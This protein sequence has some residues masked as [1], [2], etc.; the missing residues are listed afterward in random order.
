ML[1]H[2]VLAVSAICSGLANLAL[3][4]TLLHPLGL[5]GV[6]LGTLIP[7]T[8]ECIGFVLPYATRAI[9][10]SFGEVR[11]Q[12]LLPTLIPALPMAILVYGLGDTMGPLSIASLLVVVGS[13][14]LIYLVGY[15]SFSVTKGE[16]QTVHNFLITT[17]ALVGSNLKRLR[18][19]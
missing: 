2:Q 3:S 15:F 19:S 5:T 1:K 18:M 14:A 4:I 7:T 17:A 16:R 13:G 9:G 12:I 8:I 10:I 6:A 11:Q